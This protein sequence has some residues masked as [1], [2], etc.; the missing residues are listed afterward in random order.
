MK[1]FF[2]AVFKAFLVLIAVAILVAA[3][4]GLVEWLG[5]ITTIAIISG[6]IFIGLVYAFYY[7]QKFDDDVKRMR[8]KIEGI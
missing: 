7:Q 3:I 2:K 5:S 6:L 1:R 4:V 8:D